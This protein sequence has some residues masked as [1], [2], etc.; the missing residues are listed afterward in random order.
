[1]GDEEHLVVRRVSRRDQNENVYARPTGLRENVETAISG[2]EIRM[3]TYMHDP[4]DCAKTL[5]LR[6]RVGDLDL[7]GRRKRYTS[8]RE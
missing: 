7:P 6:F 5:K 1:M 3:K 8:S 2:E 4:L